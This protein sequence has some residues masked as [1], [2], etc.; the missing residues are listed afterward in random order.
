M[1]KLAEDRLDRS[2]FIRGLFSFYFRDKTIKYNDSSFCDFLHDVEN[3]NL[4]PMF[5]YLKN[6]H[7]YDRVSQAFFVNFI[8]A[9]CP[10][11]TLDVNELE[12]E[13][14]INKE[15]I[16]SIAYGDSMRYPYSINDAIEKVK[17]FKI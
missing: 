3:S 14:G 7:Q 10:I 15:M 2:N 6:S 16:R 11:N 1:L 8:D 4:A 17:I 12:Q 13:L 5:N 9:F